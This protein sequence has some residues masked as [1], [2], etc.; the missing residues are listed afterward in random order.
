MSLP[1][2]KMVSLISLMRR[3]KSF[4]PWGEGDERV[5]EAPDSMN[6]RIPSFFA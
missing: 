5:C 6:P 3:W 2:R 4:K 1:E